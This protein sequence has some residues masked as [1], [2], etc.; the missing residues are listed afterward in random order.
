VTEPLLPIRDDVARRLAGTPLVVML[1]VDGTLAPITLRPGDAAVPLETQRAVSALAVA[2]GVVVVLV[3]GRSVGDARRMVGVAN[4]WIVGNHGYEIIGPDGETLIDPQVAS[5]QPLIAQAGRRIQPRLAGVPG[6]IF[7]DKGWTLT[8][9]YRL[10]DPALVPKVRAALEETVAA[11]GLRL[12]EGKMVFEVRPPAP[13]NKG[14]A[15]L[16]LGRNLGAFSDEG[17]LV[18]I[19]D[20]RTDEDAFR[21]LRSHSKASVTVRVS[22]EEGTST[23]AEYRV[24]DPSEVLVFLEE[25]QARRR[26]GQ[27]SSRP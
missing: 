9:H 2:S 23:A 20:D 10:A 27:P 25:L 16:K 11:L 8:I 15:V 7:E 19:G 1:D 4:V 12:T 21:A 24:R 3:S 18:F 14:T 26:S 13:I 5:H 22:D 17:A 6:V